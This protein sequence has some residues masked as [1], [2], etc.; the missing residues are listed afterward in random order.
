MEAMYERDPFRE[1]LMILGE[2]FD[3]H[4]ALAKYPPNVTALDMHQL[5]RSLSL[6]QRCLLTLKI[7]Q[8][9]GCN[10]RIHIRPS[11]FGDMFLNRFGSALAGRDVTYYR[12]LDEEEIEN[13]RMV[14]HYSCLPTISANL[15]Y[16]SRIISDNDTTIHRDH[17]RIGLHPHKWERLYAP[18]E[19]PS[20]LTTRG[21]DAR[22]GILWASRLDRQKRPSLLPLI[23][24]E[25]RQHRPKMSMDVFGTSVFGHFDPRSLRDLSNLDY[26]GPYEDFYSLDLSRYSL[27]IYT[28]WCDGLPNVLLEAMAAG[29]IVIAPDVGGI[30]ELVI[31][32]E[33][34]ILLPSLASDAEMAEAY[35]DAIVR[36]T[37][38]PELSARLVQG[39][40]DLIRTRH[41]WQAYVRRVADIFNL[42][43][44]ATIDVRAYPL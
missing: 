1:I 19:P 43:D 23:A 39:A 14:V 26:H 36:L 25:L 37:D 7:I 8:S 21:P 17:H 38:D 42:D 12:F 18:I 5:S 28:S 29:L 3:G 15:P 32:G 9:S 35:C 41:S 11:T 30:A 31:D 44:E 22:S 40:S 33:T 13:A 24:A 6:E 10:A 16:I 4:S 27:F 34:G 2:D 20:P